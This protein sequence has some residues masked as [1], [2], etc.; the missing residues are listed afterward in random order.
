MTGNPFAYDNSS[1]TTVQPS[2]TPVNP[3]NLEKDDISIATCTVKFGQKP[4]F[5]KNTAAPTWLSI[6]QTQKI[7]SE[8]NFENLSGTRNFVN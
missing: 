6:F 4:T 7:H 1:G 5:I 3:A 2:R 8:E